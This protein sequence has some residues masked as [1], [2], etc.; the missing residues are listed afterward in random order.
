MTFP[1]WASHFVSWPSD[2]GRHIAECLSNGTAKLVSDGSYDPVSQR[3]VASFTICGTDHSLRIK[4]SLPSPGPFSIQDSYRGELA[5]IYGGL[6]AVH[7]LVDHFSITAGTLCV[8]CDGKAALTQSVL[9]GHLPPRPFVAHSDVIAA[10]RHIV[11]TTPLTLIPNHVRGHQRERG[12]YQGAVLIGPLDELASLNEEIDEDAN[13]FRRRLPPED[14]PLLQ[15]FPSSLWVLKVLDTPILHQHRRSLM[16]HMS[17]PDLMHY[18][19]ESRNKFGPH[20]H[21]VINWP[22]TTRCMSNLTAK[23]RLH[24]TKIATTFVAVR[25]RQKLRGQSHLDTCPRCIQ[26]SL[27]TT[28][29]SVA[30]LLSCPSP[31]NQALWNTSLV[32][33]E[34][35]LVAQVTDPRL[36]VMIISAL[37]SC[38]SGVNP[39][40]PGDGYHALWQLQMEVGWQ[41]LLEGRMVVGWSE[42]QDRYYRLQGLPSSR[43][44]L[45]WLT[46]LLR[47]LLDI[48]WDQWEHRNGILHHQSEGIRHSELQQQ[49][50]QEFQL[51][52]HRT[53]ALRRL[54][55]AGLP[56]ILR[57]RTIQ[58]EQWLEL[59][60]AYRAQPVPDCS[61]Q[62]QQEFMRNF[63][64]R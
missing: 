24:T 15:H 63:L 33:L 56:S 59:V 30:H 14:Y 55:S 53:P 28:T 4:G 6:V 64:Q 10:I 27:P 3:C 12:G 19:S 45:R 49:V 57:R 43:N 17:S 46:L 31:P 7:R 29:E 18:W 20:D 5:G 38:T 8:A 23:R 50:R 26:A 11:Q 2:Q 25:R 37:R 13:D 22:A 9:Y 60:Q 16:H 21:S 34:E 61:L 36:T 47:K 35:W 41:S 42:A 39:S 62:R 44:G 58:L 52:A 54:F 51:G 40:P 32:E 1:L 48:A